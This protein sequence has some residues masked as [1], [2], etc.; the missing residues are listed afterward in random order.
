M[1]SRLLGATAGILVILVLIWRLSAGADGRQDQGDGLSRIVIPRYSKTPA[2]RPRTWLSLARSAALGLLFL[3]W[4]RPSAAAVCAGAVPDLATAIT[5]NPASAHGYV[6]RPRPGTEFLPVACVIGIAVVARASAARCLAMLFRKTFTTFV[7]LFTPLW[8]LWWASRRLP[9]PGTG[10]PPVS[11]PNGGQAG[12]LNR[13]IAIT[14]APIVV[15]IDGHR[16]APAYG[17]LFPKNG[18]QDV[19]S[20]NP[21][22]RGMNF[23]V[24]PRFLL[25][26][27]FNGVARVPRRRPA[28]PIK[29]AS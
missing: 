29:G 1:S 8:C 27:C 6:G 21:P 3:G 13:R 17:L 15:R 22:L 11:A 10:R 26:S 2:A 7:P 23:P 19:P 16:H 9:A 4:C 14:H 20:A 12:A 24:S 25:P 28:H 18:R 5:R